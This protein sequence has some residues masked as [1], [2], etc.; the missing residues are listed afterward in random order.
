MQVEK[1]H[2]PQNFHHSEN[3]RASG[4]KNTVSVIDLDI[5]KLLI[6]TEVKYT[7]ALESWYLPVVKGGVLISRIVE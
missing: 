5:L 7:L 3:F 6:S 2:R 1:V 4:Q